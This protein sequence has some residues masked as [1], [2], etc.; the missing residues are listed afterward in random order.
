MLVSSRLDPSTPGLTTYC[1]I[2]VKLLNT[3]P[4]LSF[5][6]YK[7]KVT[8]GPCRNVEDSDST[9]QVAEIPHLRTCL[10]AVTSQDGFPLLPPHLSSLALL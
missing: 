10:S 9:C 3:S 2:P 5:P 8:T 4:G 1:G 7:V 6:F